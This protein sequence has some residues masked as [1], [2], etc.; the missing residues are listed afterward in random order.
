MSSPHLGTETQ[1]CKEEGPP[2][3][4][5]IL[6][7]VKRDDVLESVRH[8]K[9]SG[10]DQDSLADLPRSKAASAR[11]PVLS[12]RRG[13]RKIGWNVTGLRTE[14]QSAGRLWPVLGRSEWWSLG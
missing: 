12:W 11:D 14:E 5:V 10:G 2:A 6:S 13:H 4:T 7:C 3:H 8:S 9:L 1:Y